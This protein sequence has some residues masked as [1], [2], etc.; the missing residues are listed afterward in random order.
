MGCVWVVILQEFA[1]TGKMVTSFT[2]AMKEE[3]TEVMGRALFSDD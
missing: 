1:K 2:E 3:K